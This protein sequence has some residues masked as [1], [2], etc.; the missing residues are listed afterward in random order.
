MKLEG[1]KKMNKSVKFE[2][3]LKELDETVKELEDGNLS[4]DE[5]IQKYKKGI[6]LANKCE[7]ML[8]EAQNEVIDKLEE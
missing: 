3:L 2:D 5:S 6:S 8:E 1:K 4:L 7:K